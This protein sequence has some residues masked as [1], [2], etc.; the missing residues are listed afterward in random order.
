MILGNQVE[1]TLHCCVLLARLPENT[2]VATKHLADFHGVPK[3]Y[4]SKALQALSLAGLVTGTLGP[5]GGYQL[6][7]AAEDITF[8][9]IVEAVEGRRS[10]FECTEIRRNNPCLGPQEKPQSICSIAK[11]MHQADKAWRRELRAV[12]LA[13]VVAEVDRKLAASSKRAIAEWFRE[14]T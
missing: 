2:R 11:V 6:A 8:L 5:R 7:R 10:S 13:R 1:W 14:R 4:L 9:D 3:E 12:T